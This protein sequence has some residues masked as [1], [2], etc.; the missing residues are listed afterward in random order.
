[1]QDRRHWTVWACGNLGRLPSG[2]KPRLHTSK[3]AAAILWLLNDL[4]RYSMKR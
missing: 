4:L 1:M 3:V 2:A